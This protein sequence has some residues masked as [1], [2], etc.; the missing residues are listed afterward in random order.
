MRFLPQGFLVAELLRARSGKTASNGEQAQAC[1]ETPSKHSE[2]IDLASTGEQALAAHAGAG[3]EEEAPDA[4]PETG[5]GEEDLGAGVKAS[6]GEEDEG[7][8]ALVGL[9][10]SEEGD[11]VRAIPQVDGADVE[12]E[13]EGERGGEG[14]GRRGDEGEGVCAGRDGEQELDTCLPNGQVEDQNKAGHSRV[15]PGRG[16]DDAETRG[17]EKDEIED[18]EEEDE[19]SGKHGDFGGMQNY[20]FDGNKKG[21]WLVD[22]TNKGNVWEPSPPCRACCRLSRA[23]PRGAALACRMQMP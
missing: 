8:R 12:E 16:E 20:I 5:H 19:D 15:V 3:C 14:K 6:H 7:A 11:R 23:H 2:Q 13:G 10:P 17:V 21:K 22:A 1:K 9:T 4:D 18:E